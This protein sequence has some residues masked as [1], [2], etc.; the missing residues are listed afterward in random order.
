MI[1]H[2]ITSFFFNLIVLFVVILLDSVIY[3]VLTF[4]ATVRRR[5]SLA[6]ITDSTRRSC[7]C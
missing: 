7:E 4:I 6:V 5:R 3:D 1:V 2:C